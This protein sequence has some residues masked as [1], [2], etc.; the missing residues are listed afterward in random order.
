MTMTHYDCIC[1]TLSM[2]S[3]FV[4]LPR[5]RLGA[6]VPVLRQ[7]YRRKRLVQKRAT[8]LIQEIRKTPKL[9]E[10]SYSSALIESDSR[11]ATGKY[12]IHVFPCSLRHHSNEALITVVFDMLMWTKRSDCQMCSD[13]SNGEYVADHEH[14][15]SPQHSMNRRFACNDL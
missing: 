4:L 11:C 15:D 8:L 1:M 5:L 6:Q 2:V 3:S 13:E 10:Q 7:R 9:T 12:A 14:E